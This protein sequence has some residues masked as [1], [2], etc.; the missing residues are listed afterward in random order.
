AVVVPRDAPRSE[1]VL[2]EMADPP[3]SASAPVADRDTLVPLAAATLSAPVVA[4]FTAPPVSF[5][6][7]TRSPVFEISRSPFVFV[8]LRV[9]TVGSRV[10]EPG[11]VAPA[12]IVKVP[13]VICSPLPTPIDPGFATVP[14]VSATVT[15]AAEIGAFRLTVP[16]A[17]PALR[18][19]PV[20][21]TT[22]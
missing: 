10:P 14:A 22:A 13:A 2:P 3:V 19:T 9:P 21:A 12:L 15:P 8:A 7:S 1:T 17:P 20:P 5:A 11:P 4:T 18:V 16:P 6:V